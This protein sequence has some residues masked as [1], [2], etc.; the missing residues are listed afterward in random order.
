MPERAAYDEAMLLSQARLKVPDQELKQ[1]K[2]ETITSQTMAGP[3]KRPWGVQGGFA[4]VYKFATQSGKLR[5]LRCFLAKMDPD[6]QYRYERI[7]AYFAAHAPNIAVDFIYHDAGILLKET[8]YGQIHSKNYPLIE[9]EWV[10]GMTLIDYVNKLCQKRDTATLADVVRQWGTIM[11]TLQKAQISHGDLAGGNVMVKPDGRLVL[12]DYDGVYIPQFAGLDG[13]VLGQADYQ[14]PQMA[15]R[16]FNERTDDFSAWV[17]Y[18][19]LLALQLKP[20][21]WDRYIQLNAQG[22]PVDANLLFRRADFVDPDQSALFAELS[23]I[24]E[25]R[26]LKACTILIQ[27]CK[28]SITQVP[29]FDPAVIDPEAEKKQALLLLEKAIQDNDEGEIIRLWEINQLDTYAPAQAHA[30]RVAQARQTVQAFK[31]LQKA[32]KARSL[33]Q[34]V[35][36]FDPLVFNSNQLTME[37]GEQL[38]LIL[39]FAQ[40]YQTE[41][42]QAISS[43]WEAIETSRFP[44]LLKLTPQEQQRLS[45][46]QQ[47]K[48]VLVKFRLAL[49]QKNIQAIAASYDSTLLDTCLAVTAREREILQ[50]AQ[51]FAQAYQSDD[52]QAIVAASEAI[53]NFSYRTQLAFTAQEQQRVD[54]ARQRKLALMKFRMALM[55]KNMAQIIASYDWVLDDCT[56]ITQQE[57]EILRLAKLFVQASYKHDDQALVD[58]WETIVRSSYQNF[59]VL[60]PA[61]QLRLRLFRQGGAALQKFHLA[62]ASGQ[63]RQIV[64]DYDPLL[65]AHTSITADERTQLR[66]A[67]AFVQASQAEDD[68]ALASTW[69]EMQA[70]GQQQLFVLTTQEQQRIELAQRRKAALLKFRLALMGKRIQ[71][72]VADYNPILDDSHNVT[73]AEKQQLALARQFILAYQSDQDASILAAWTAVQNSPYRRSFLF[74]EM[75]TQR[76][77]LART[78]KGK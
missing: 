9:M 8:I 69:E 50:A 36:A 70:T 74:T 62:L 15:L 6:M 18:T 45:L 17:I 77:A 51:E 66:L 13:I 7:G 2:I 64:T 27:A 52:D 33:R 12:I 42:D 5:A 61:E 32:L 44:N 57:R 25:T 78:R 4:V 19:A 34:I 21:L 29:V 68:Q 23:Q 53:Q 54:L 16:P 76:I 58:T 3:I 28:Q 26:L 1:G 55:S 35:A 71:Q 46:A 49:M 20:E 72:V 22:E 73:A 24:Q 10:E 31:R 43:S 59:F 47:R 56:S 39:P 37:Q 65:D 60:S 14:H 38:L 40:A 30:A 75:E 63:P 11:S 41:D 67:Q 48:A